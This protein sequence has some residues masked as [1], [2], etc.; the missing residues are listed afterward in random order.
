MASLVCRLLVVP[1]NFKR[2]MRCWAVVGRRVVGSASSGIIHLSSNA[3]P[4]LFS[5]R[6]FSKHTNDNDTLFLH[7]GPSGD[8]WTGPSLFAAKH[9]QPDYVKSFHL[10]RGVCGDELLELLEENPWW[11]QQIYDGQDLP[12]ELETYLEIVDEPTTS[13]EETK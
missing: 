1:N 9:L 8:C 12:K 2:P 4:L 3:R 13:T 6:S 10:K 7:V 5:T 11:S